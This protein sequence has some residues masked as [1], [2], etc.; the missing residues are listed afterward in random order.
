MRIKMADY[1][2]ITAGWPSSVYN[3]D[4]D[5]IEHLYYYQRCSLPA[6]TVASTVD[7][8]RQFYIDVTGATGSMSDLERA[9]YDNKGIA[10]GSLADRA[11][12]WWSGVIT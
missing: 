7:F 4:L 9:Y 5:Y 2:V 11:Y 12:T 10:A 8:E 6:N 3:Q 1:L